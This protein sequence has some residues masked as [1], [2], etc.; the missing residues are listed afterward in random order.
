MALLKCVRSHIDDL[1][2]PC[3]CGLEED[4]CVVHV[5]RGVHAVDAQAHA[6]IVANELHLVLR[7][8]AKHGTVNRRST[9]AQVH[10]RRSNTCGTNGVVH[11]QEAIQLSKLTSRNNS[12]GNIALE[13]RCRTCQPLRPWQSASGCLRPKCSIAKAHYFP[14][15]STA[16][17]YIRSSSFTL[18]Y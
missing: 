4:T 10:V 2:L 1:C 18:K 9:V 8:G 11:R 12:L 14:A 17:R 15:T 16:T 5:V 6:N 3:E 7:L 13:R